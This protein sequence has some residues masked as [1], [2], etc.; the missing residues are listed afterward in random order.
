[1]TAVQAMAHAQAAVVRLA[2]WTNFEVSDLFTA[3]DWEQMP[4]GIRKSLGRKFRE[5]ANADKRL[6]KFVRRTADNHSH[7][8]R[9]HP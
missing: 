7:Y 2:P 3:A 6:L 4:A 9:L 5:W 8:V 1:M